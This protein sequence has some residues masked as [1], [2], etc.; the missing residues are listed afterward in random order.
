MSFSFK[1]KIRQINPGFL[2]FD[3][4]EILQVNLGDMCNQRCL[5]CHVDAGPNG[6]HIM[7]REVMEEIISFLRDHKGYTLDITG[8]CPE[9]HPDFSFFINE[10][11]QLTPRTL[12]RTNLT[13]LTEKEM[14]WVSQCYR[15]LSIVLM[16]SLP[17]YTKESVDQQRGDGVFEKCVDALKRLNELGYGDSHELNLI[18]NPGGDFLPPPQRVLEAEYKKVLFQNYRVKFNNLLTITNAPL[19]RFKNYLKKNEKLEKYTDLLVESFNPEAAAHIMCRSLVSVNWQGILY[20][21]DFNQAAGL[22]IRDKAGK[23]MKSKEIEETIEGR[24]E[25]EMGEHCYCCTAG[26]GSSCTGV[27][28]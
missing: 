7:H 2:D 19:G 9:L 5:H 24:L 22:P 10:V 12:V 25:I 23:I 6:T 13:V 27:L 14:D 28:V 4:L 21:C 17:C 11:Y 8:G 20:N 26:A 3:K 15:D 16:A 1:E 18:Y